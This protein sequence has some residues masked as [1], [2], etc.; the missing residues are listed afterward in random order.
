M[1]KEKTHWMQNPNKNY[2][3]HPDL[4]NGGDAILT[5]ASAAWEAVENP[6]IG[7]K[8]EKRVIHF[9]EQHKWL[10]PFICNETNAKMIVKVTGEKYIEDSVGKKIKIGISQTKIKK[11]E[12]DCLRIREVYQK[13]L[14]NYITNEQVAEI[15]ELCAKAGKKEDQILSILKVDEFAQLPTSKFQAIKNKLTLNIKQN[16]NN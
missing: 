10:K 7:T 5:I 14:T 13:D 3:G 2:L 6:T 12:V 16:E 1:T 11:E 8:E 15:K 4:P 9:A